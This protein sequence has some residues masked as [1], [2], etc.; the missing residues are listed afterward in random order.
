MMSFVWAAVLLVL[1]VIGWATNLIGLPGNWFN[2]LAI[3]V[4][5][6]AAADSGRTAIGGWCVLAVVVL[7]VLGE[8]IEFV[9][10]AM[11]VTKAGGSRRGAVL[12][13]VG[14]LLGGLLGAIVGLPIPVIGTIAGVLILASFGALAGAVIGERWQGRDWEQ[15]LQIGR[16]AFWGRLLGT[17]GKLL[18]GAVI[19]ALVLAA[20]LLA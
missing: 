14:S 17:L 13:I 16:A 11:G 7:A 12:A 9:A 4:Y 6:Y 3:A 15:S 20:L 18:T 19:V 2:V 5:A 8:I 1:V 10:G